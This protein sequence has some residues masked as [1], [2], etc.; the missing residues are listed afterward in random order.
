MDQY[1]GNQNVGLE[2]LA[3]EW[4]CLDHIEDPTS[5]DDQFE[6]VLWFGMTG[7]GQ[8]WT[9]TATTYRPLGQYTKATMVKCEASVAQDFSTDIRVR[10][11]ESVGW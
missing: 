3:A 5:S 9:M 6:V 4:A 1:Y 10:Q 2:S 7:E 11:I 8:N